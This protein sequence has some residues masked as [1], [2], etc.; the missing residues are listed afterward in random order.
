[1]WIAKPLEALSPDE[2]RAWARCQT[3]L[4]ARGE[5]V[6]LSQTLVWSQATRSL[7]G[8]TYLVMNAEEGVGGIVHSKEPHKA[9]PTS[10]DCTNGPLLH[11]DGK[12]LPRQLA[13]F[14]MAVSKLSRRFESLNMRPR[15]EK[16][17][18]ERRL[19]A[20]PIEAASLSEAAT[21]HI[22]V[23]PDVV[24]QDSRAS[25]RL[26]RTLSRARQAE[27]VA[28]WSRAEPAVIGAF[29]EGM[30]AFGK[31]R[32]FYVPEPAWFE[33]LL[34]GGGERGADTAPAFTHAFNDEGISFHRVDAIAKNSSSR[35]RL[36]V[37]VTPECMH[38]L[39]GYDEREAGA[40]AALSTA[41][42][43]HFSALD[44]CRTMGLPFYDLNGF[45]TGAASG[46]YAGVSGFK[47]QFGGEV[48]EYASP[49]IVV[50][51]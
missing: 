1:M 15:W 30:R 13:T 8:G 32:G 22:P 16:T 26:R 44:A 37:C 3:A 14:A 39:F 9:G 43:A 11:W 7:G 34:S 36:L 29:A 25:P 27:V 33:A 42:V 40:S 6:P 45:M 20:L 41:S 2:R 46:S 4:R 23:A 18:L 24:D 50:R 51:A 48:L 10:F 17:F 38:Y 35:T 31:Q 12:E 21:I 19:L 28:D 5:A 49:E 47:E